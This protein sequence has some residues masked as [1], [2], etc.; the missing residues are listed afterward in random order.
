M[1]GHRLRCITPR[2]QTVAIF[3]AADPRAGLKA[4]QPPF[5][6]SAP[7]IRDVVRQIERNDR[8]SPDTREWE[9][10]PREKGSERQI[11]GILVKEIEDVLLFPELRGG[12]EV[13]CERLSIESVECDKRLKIPAPTDHTRPESQPLVGILSRGGSNA[14]D[15]N[16]RMGYQ[17]G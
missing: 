14:A 11:P 9:M 13:I 4:E 15:T 7:R 12:T 10:L 17:K 5:L 3:L 8:H 6:G 1:F 16:L 2:C